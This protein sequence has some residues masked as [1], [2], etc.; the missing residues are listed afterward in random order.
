MQNPLSSITTTKPSS[1]APPIATKT[2]VPSVKIDINT[3][4][5]LWS[6]IHPK[7]SS[8][9]K[10]GKFMADAINELN[11]KELIVKLNEV[12]FTE[13]KDISK[14]VHFSEHRIKSYKNICD[15]VCE[16]FIDALKDTQEFNQNKEINTKIAE[17]ILATY[18]GFIFGL[19]KKMIDEED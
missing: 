13:L 6:K 7:F 16:N 18:S 4:E 11:M 19:T 8:K 2:V 5:V 15:S 17:N 3:P 12:L 9:F 1:M 10:K 14:D